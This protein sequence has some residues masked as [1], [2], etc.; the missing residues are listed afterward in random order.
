MRISPTTSPRLPGSPR[1]VLT[2]AVAA[3]I[4]IAGCDSDRG[5]AVLCYVGGTMRPVL[6][7]LVRQYEAETGKKILLDNGDS[8]ACVIKAEG[9]GRGDLIVVHDPFHDVLAKKG[10]LSEGWIV[11]VVEP[12]IA[13]PKG[14]PKGI[15]GLADLAKPGLRLILTDPRYSTAAAIVDATARKAGIAEAIEKNVVTRT[16]SGGEAANAVVLGNADATFVW[17]AVIRLREDKLDVVEIEPALRPVHGVDPIIAEG[18]GPIDPSFVR[19]TIDLLR[20]SARPDDARRFAEFAASPK[21]AEAWKRQGFVPAPGNGRLFPEPA[22]IG[23]PPEKDGPILVSCGA[24][25]RAPI[26]EIAAAFT[27]KMGRT[28][29]RDYGGS[30]VVLSRLKVSGKGDVFIPGDMWYVDL[31]EKDGL[32]ASRADVCHLVPVILVGKGNPK[33]IAG[34]ADLVRPGLRLGLGRSSACQ[35]GR[36]SEAIIEKAGLDREAIAK[37][38]AF[39]S[40]TVNELGIQIET[41]HLDAAIVWDAVALQY[42]KSAD[43]VPIPLEKNEPARVVAAVLKGARDPAAAEAFVRFVAGDEGKA[44]LRKHGYR[45][46]PPR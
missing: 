3:A 23:A 21:A 33:G 5:D 17:R 41:G 43:A 20:S 44:V 30:G 35:V 13:V 40:L 11:A 28:V 16:R 8:G 12:A 38:L 4:A 29:E 24:G 45:I 14:N 31:A 18:V 2:A 7:E 9:T 1:A 27:A 6:E 22:V 46:D 39:S 37:N 34:P 32:V 15:R 26:E 10:L 42:E 19:V 25:L 36:S